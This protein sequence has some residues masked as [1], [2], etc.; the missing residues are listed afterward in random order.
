MIYTMAPVCPVLVLG[1]LPL[2]RAV[3]VHWLTPAPLGDSV[4]V[5]LKVGYHCTLSNTCLARNL[6]HCNAQ[7]RLSICSD[8]SIIQSN[9]FPMEP[10]KPASLFVKMLPVSLKI[11]M[12]LN[13]N[14][15]L[16]YTGFKIKTDLY[17]CCYWPC[18]DC[19]CETMSQR[20]SLWICNIDQ[21][22]VGIVFLQAVWWP[23]M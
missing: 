8:M 16:F 9:H 21:F 10:C 22:N 1:M 17:T 3:L 5:T 11:W 20:E 19:K 7:G 2:L 4:I 13:G 6:C 14:C 23:M 15:I 18:L 12:L